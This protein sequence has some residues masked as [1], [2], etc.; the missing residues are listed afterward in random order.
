[1]SKLATILDPALGISF[2]DDEPL[3]EMHSYRGLEAGL[4]GIYR[5]MILG[6]PFIELLGLE[7]L[8]SLQVYRSELIDS[9]WFV[10]Q[11]DADLTTFHSVAVEDARRQVREQLGPGFFNNPSQDGLDLP[12]GQIGL[13][14]WLLAVWKSKKDYEAEHRLAQHRPTIDWS[15]VLRK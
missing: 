6:T 8:L 4:P 9:R 7:Q 13:I 11:V 12:S 14:A 1:M 15:G 3:R 10:M 2:G 5:L